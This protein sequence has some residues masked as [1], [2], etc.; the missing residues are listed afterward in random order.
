MKLGMLGWMLTLGS[1]LAAADPAAVAAALARPVEARS[2]PQ[3]GAV[4]L[5]DE[6]VVT[7]DGQ[8]RTTTE[9]H[10]LIRILRE[11]A[12]GQLGDQKIPF[13]GD[14]QICEVLAARTHLPGGGTLEPEPT[15]I[16]EVSDPEAADAPFYSSARLKVVSFPGLLVGAAIELRYRVSPLANPVEPDPFM[17]E[18]LFGGAEP[19]LG[20]SLTLR[21]PRRV[22][23]Q[24]E[25]FNGCPAPA[26]RADGPWV[27]YAWTLRDQPQIQYETGMVPYQDLVPRLVWTVV[28]DRG[29]LGRWLFRRF[30][31]AAG[32]DPGISAEARELTAG[33]AGSEAKVKRL[34]RFV[35]QDVQNV[36]LTLGR[37]GWRPTP[38]ATILANRYADVR[39]KF[40]LF[41]ALLRAVGLDARPALV[42][43]RRVRLSS[44][45]CAAEYQAILARVQLP[46]GVRFFN[47]AQG[48]APLGE[49]MPEDSGRPALLAGAAGGQAI[50][51]P[52]AEP[53]RQSARARWDLALD[54]RG[55]LT[56]RVTLRF[57][58]PFDQQIRAL[59]GELNEDERGVLFQSLAD[60]IKRGARLTG[61]Q[62]SDLLDLAAPPVVKVTFRIPDFACR[63]GRTMILN[64]PGEL[65]PLGEPL[66]RPALPAVRHPFLVP[67]SFA[68]RAT[69][70]LRLP[71]GYGIAYRPR[72]AVVREGPFAFRIACAQGAG[73]LL[74]TSTVT[75]RGQV[76]HPGAYPAL[77][78]AFGAA[79][80][81][82]NGLILL[83]RK[84]L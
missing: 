72:T 40:V 4:I 64:L 35:T 71:A 15:G 11:R 49:P 69:V 9:G 43:E 13:R 78:R 30:Q 74:L 51:T 36:A 12:L 24:Y 17:G 14:A 32:P 82:G 7:L 8:G 18:M 46:S 2:Y 63:Q 52:A 31:D 65:V 23:L 26:V 10:L 53:R 33:L 67:A 39:D 66:A 22:P 45:A 37:V 50:T 38:A 3:A 47:L 48:M 81:P 70:S 62:V 56:G 76:V 19:L 6:K 80:G 73:R 28:R 34:A 68:M 83:E 54:A 57:G 59:L 29:Q 42:Q 58:G 55:T 41:Q 60:G 25:M 77:W 1:A 27:D 44:L 20:A 16:T 84:R 61:Y 75:W 5:L 21:V 79:G